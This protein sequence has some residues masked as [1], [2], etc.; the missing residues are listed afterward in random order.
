MRSARA[1]SKLPEVSHVDDASSFIP[2]D[3]DGKAARS[4]A[5]P[6]NKLCRR[7]RSRRTLSRRRPTPKMSTR[8]NEGARRLTE[9]AE[10]PDGSGARRGAAARCRRSPRSPRRLR[11]L[12]TSADGQFRLAAAAPISTALQASLQAA[13]GHAGRPAARSRA[14]LDDAGRPRA[15]LDRAEGRSGRQRRH[16]SFRARGAGCRADATEGPI[17]IL[18]AGDTVIHAFVEAGALGAAVDRDPAVARAQAARRRA[19]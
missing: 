16:A 4:F 17:S 10:Q 15:R 18:E 19:A 9:A 5:T 8:L 6:A 2:E 11:P 12:A 14:R 13:A 1:L 3:Q 7:L